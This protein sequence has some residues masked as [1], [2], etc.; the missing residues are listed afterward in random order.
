MSSKFVLC[1]KTSLIFPFFVFFFFLKLLI[2]ILLFLIS[3]QFL[4]IGEYL[5]IRSQIKEKPI[6]LD[7]VNILKFCIKKM[8]IPN[9][10]LC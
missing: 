8:F 9:K 5:R 10:G 3:I 7:R 4:F 2:F 1:S 6:N